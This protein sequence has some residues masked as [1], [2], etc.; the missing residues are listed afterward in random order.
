MLFRLEV[1]GLENLPPP[2]TRS[3]I[4]IN[5]VSFL[6]A[7]IMLSLMD[8]PPVFA[9]DHGIAERWWIKPFLKLAD[10]RPLDPARPLA[11][12]AL[13]NEVRGGRR[14]VIFP[15]G[16]ITVTGALMKI[17]D[18][19]ALIADRSEALI[20]PVR[21]VGPERTY[22]SRLDAAQ[23]GRRLFPKM[24]V[25]F[26]PPERLA[27]PA[28]LRGRARRRAA[29]AALY[30]MMSDLIFRDDRYPPH[31]ARRVRG[32][33]EIARLVADRGP[34]SAR[35]LA[36]LADV[37][38][39][40]RGAGAQ[41]RRDHGAGEIVGLM[42]PNANGSAVTFMALQAAGRVPAMLNFTA[43]P[44]NLV[45]ACETAR[46]GLVLTSRAFVDKG[47]LA[48]RRRGAFGRSRASSGS[49]TCARARRGPTSCAPR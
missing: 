49:R 29:G 40:R 9:I 16:R 41:D 46:I 39:R 25:T 19:A 21:L 43:G 36:H 3:V 48:P 20:T 34:G 33:G 13:V 30:D 38:H 32:V 23:V 24:T 2:G 7:P 35:R 37:P 42:L 28:G 44:N 5:H 11:A 31:A 17:Y 45:A 4:A 1:K 27:I 14:L 15:E 8:R 10:A 26:L 22:F 18:G 6:D 12:R 47:D